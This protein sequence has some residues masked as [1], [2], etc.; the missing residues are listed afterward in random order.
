MT[1]YNS[2]FFSPSNLPYFFL[3]FYFFSAG[4]WPQNSLVMS[5]FFSIPIT[6][7]TNLLTPFLLLQLLTAP[8]SFSV[9]FFFLFSFLNVMVDYSLFLSSILF[10]STATGHNNLSSLSLSVPLSFFFISHSHRHR[11][12]RIL[13]SL[14]FFFSYTIITN[15]QS[16]LSPSSFL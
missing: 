9:L 10:P 11:R 14:F 15:N 13:L 5:S 16:L 6:T 3:S 8:Y 4:W 7:M 2:F 12:L 1:Y